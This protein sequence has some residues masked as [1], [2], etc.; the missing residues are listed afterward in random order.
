V[1]QPIRLVPKPSSSIGWK[2]QGRAEFGGHRV[3]RDEEVADPGLALE[4][5]ADAGVHDHVVRAAHLAVLGDGPG[6][7]RRG[8]GRTDTA[9]EDVQLMAK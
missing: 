7:G 3:G 4:R 8:G 2:P 6:R 1:L 9:D 5:A